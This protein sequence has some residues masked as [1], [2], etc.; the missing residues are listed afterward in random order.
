[1]QRKILALSIPGPQ[2]EDF[3]GGAGLNEARM[4]C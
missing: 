3:N 2:A 1:M 4:P